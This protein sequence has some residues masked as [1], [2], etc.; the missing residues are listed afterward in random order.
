MTEWQGNQPLPPRFEM[1]PPPERSDW[2][3]ELLGG[4]LGLSIRPERGKEPNWFWRWTQYLVLGFRWRWKPLE[5]NENHW[6]G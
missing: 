4:P 6:S 5:H 2:Q 3:C 1:H